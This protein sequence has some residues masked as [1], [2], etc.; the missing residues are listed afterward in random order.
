M[1]LI[2]K[3]FLIWRVL[4][5]LPVFLGTIFIPYRQH[6]DFTNILNRISSDSFLQNFLVF[7]WANF[8]GVHFLSIAINGYISEGRFLPLYPLLIKLFAFILGLGK[9]NYETAFISGLLIS[10]GAFFIALTL[11]YKIVKVEFSEK[12]AKWAMLFMLSYPTAF[13][14]GSIYSESLFLLLTLISFYFTLKNKWFYSSVSGML[15]S[16]TRLVGI[17]VLPALLFEFFLRNRKRIFLKL[18]KNLFSLTSFIIIPG[19]LVGFAFYCFYKWGDALYFLNAHGELGNSRQTTSIILPVQTMYRYLK[20]IFEGF[21]YQ[22][23]WWVAVIELSFF[24]MVTFLLILAWK[25]GIKRS[26]LIFSF[27][28]FLMP[29]L[30][31]TFSGLPRYSLVLF[32]IYITCALIQSEWLKRLILALFIFLQ[33]V[34]LMMFSRGYYI[35]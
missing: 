11:F 27:L 5:F 17:F 10:N 23:E 15:L 32:P 26:Y 30:S 1:K 4:L 16:L 6:Q 19:G 20:I 22:F 24:I 8:D 31:G 13:F 2:I 7:P 9:V 12:T 28:A 33:A 29:V 21:F 34:F 35:A 25:K 18:N 14:L 3:S